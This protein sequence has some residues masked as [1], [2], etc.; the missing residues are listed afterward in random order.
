MY[1][2]P[3]GSGTGVLVRPDVPAPRVA[4]TGVDSCRKVQVPSKGVVRAPD[5][6]R[7]TEWYV[8][9]GAG[10]TRDWDA[11]AI[12]EVRDRLAELLEGVAAG[13]FGPV[14]GSYCS[15]CAHVAA[16]PEGQAAASQES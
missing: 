10:V 2:T 9:E 16:C 12:S 6:L 8:R 15:R 5:G 14:S 13:R 3:E 1:L 7:T 11:P 4:T